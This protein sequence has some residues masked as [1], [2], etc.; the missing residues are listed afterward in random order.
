MVFAY[1][2]H[3]E[4]SIEEFEQ[5]FLWFKNRYDLIS[6]DQLKEYINGNLYFKNACMLSVDDG[7]RSTYDVIFPVMKKYRMPFTIF[8]SPE[9][10]VKES[11][12]WYFIYKYLN[13]EEIKN[14][15][16]YRKLFSAEVRS[17]DAE[18]I[19]KEL[20]IDLVYDILEEVVQKHPEIEIPRGFINTKELL[21]MN[22]SGLVE[23]GAHS[24][25]H[26]ILANETVERSESE[27]RISIEELSSI[28]DKK[29]KTFA[30]P[31]GIEG[32]DYGQR[33]MDFIK[34]TSIELAFSVDPD[35]INSKCNP[36]SLPRW[37]SMARLKFGRFGKYLPSRM[38]QANIRAE[39]KKYKL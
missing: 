16:I 39:I 15:L 22:A 9:V 26:P 13:Q 20:S 4:K 18:M 2:L 1:Y 8:V 12:F 32:L 27:I 25:S 35:R 34:D 6:F 38:N 14:V 7:W 10:C 31:N 19:L 30:Y 21:E 33:E 36:Y 5:T 23:I 29:V 11:N 37:G 24:M 3:E 28:I 17:F